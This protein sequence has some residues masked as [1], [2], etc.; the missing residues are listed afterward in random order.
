MQ[1]IFMN[2]KIRQVKPD[3]PVIVCQ[4]AHGKQRE[5]NRFALVVNGQTIGW[6]EYVPTGLEAVESHDVKA[7]VEL[8]DFVEVHPEGPGLQLTTDITGKRQVISLNQAAASKK[9]PNK[10]VKIDSLKLAK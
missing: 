8:F 10:V 2:H 3:G 5:A 4:D 6:V 9:K 1:F 7:W